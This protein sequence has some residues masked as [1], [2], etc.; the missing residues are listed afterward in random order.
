[1]NIKSKLSENITLN[2]S[3]HLGGN[4]AHTSGL[5]VHNT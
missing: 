4:M 2:I 1:M 3:D 5:S